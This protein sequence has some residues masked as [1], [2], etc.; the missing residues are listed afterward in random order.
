MIDQLRENR[1]MNAPGNSA[2][3]FTLL[4]VFVACCGYAAGRIHQRRQT[5]DDR[6][7]AYRD[8]YETATRSVFSLAARAVSGR[9]TRSGT[10]VGRSAPAKTD[11][12]PGNVGAGNV[13][14]GD[15]GVGNVPVGGPAVGDPAPGNVLGN[16]PPGHSAASAVLGNVALGGSV[17]GSAA[18]AAAESDTRAEADPAEVGSPAIDPLRDRA[19]KPVAEPVGQP[20]LFR[21]SA[22]PGAAAIPAS[23]MPSAVENDATSLGFPVPP[24]PSPR[25]VAEPPAVGGLVYRPFPDPRAPRDV[26]L[27]SYPTDGG[28]GRPGFV[29]AVPGVSDREPADASRGRSAFAPSAGATAPTSGDTPSTSHSGVHDHRAGR[30]ESRVAEESPRG[31]GRRRGSRRARADMR[32]DSRAAEQG[33][34][35]ARSGAADGVR[36]PGFAGPAP[37]LGMPGPA[38][39]MPDAVVGAP[40]AEAAL[41]A[42]GTEPELESTGRHTVPDELVQAP[43]Y[44]L[45]PDRIFRARVPDPVAPPEESTTRL[46]V[47]KPRQS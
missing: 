20:A 30:S 5:E 11:A 24:P 46:P 44:R 42:A 2:L 29:P 31:E 19:P 33:A 6:E 8:G 17:S 12:P 21:R 32:A 41:A 16:S 38:S 43:T 28:S 25:V 22:T 14:P 27:P 39:G 45:P 15:P 1:S 13:G 36:S 23:R 47:P 7:E 34:D 4:A 40:G 10:A 9:R 18:A 35:A 37:F 3:I 26:V